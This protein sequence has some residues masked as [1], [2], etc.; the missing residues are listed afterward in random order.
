[1]HGDIAHKA[2]SLGFQRVR[3]FSCGA[4]SIPVADGAADHVMS[5]MVLCSVSSVP[6][7]LREVRRILKR[8][9]T[10]AFVEHVGDVKGT[11][12]RSRGWRRS[13]HRGLA[14]R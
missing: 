5:T 1:M 14:G 12:R 11:W 2:E 13:A 3:I 6:A 8:G 9:G 7:V 4:E 10:F